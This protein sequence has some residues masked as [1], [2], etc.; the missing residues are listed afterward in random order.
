MSSVN[1][2]LQSIGVAIAGL[3]FGESVHLPALKASKDL[4]PVA[5]W[6]PRKIRLEESCERNNLIGYGDWPQL[7]NDPKVNAI[8]IATPP[9]PRKQMA[10]AALEAGK[11]VLLEKPVALS[12]EEI[13]ELQRLA[14]NNRLS[15]AVDFEYRA[16]P[17]FM[18]TKRLLE[19]NVVGQPWL[20]RLDWLMSSRA[21]KSRPWNWYSQSDLGGGVIGAL[22]THAFDILHWLC[23]PSISVSGI[24]S[25]SIKE[26]H[27]PQTNTLLTVTS[28]D[29]AFAHLELSNPNYKSLVPAQV[30]L[31][32]V[33]RNGRGFWLE[34]YGSEGTIFLGSDNQNDY[35][36]GFGLW[37]A[38]SGEGLKS[39]SCDK[40]LIFPKT[41]SDGRIAPVSRLQDWWAESIRSSQ[42]MIPGLS[43]AWSSQKVCDKLRE[44]SNSGQK[45]TLQS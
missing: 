17:L 37:Y 24:L 22:G 10:I 32:S 44:S 11:H 15:V 39:I 45:I 8:V 4:N 7:L 2:S 14:I 21:N 40:D 18:Q 30:S 36:H 23:G 28:E 25:T 1:S 41:W 13:A 9:A 19:E 20:I 12:S 27:D 31:S 38:P 3:G 5:I 42:P 33:S 35:V 29:V 26:R 43:E 6:H 34:I 16:V